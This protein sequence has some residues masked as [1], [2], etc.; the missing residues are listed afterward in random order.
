MKFVRTVHSESSEPEIE[1]YSVTLAG[2]ALELSYR[3]ALKL[4]SPTTSDA[5]VGVCTNGTCSLY[6]ASSVGST[7]SVTELFSAS[8]MPTY[9]ES[10]A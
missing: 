7:S 8:D 1:P 5:N 3:R 6:V 9:S 4:T 2:C 10:V